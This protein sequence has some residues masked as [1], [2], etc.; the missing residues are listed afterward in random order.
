MSAQPTVL[1]VSAV[2]LIRRG[3]D[4]L[5]VESRYPG[6]QEPFWALPGG[7]LEDNEDVTDALIREVREETGLA[8]VGPPSVAALIWLRTDD[9]S[10]DWVTFI[11]EPSGWEGAIHADDPDGVTLQ[12]AF[13]PMDD[14]EGLLLGLRW[15]LSEPI[16]QRLRGAPLG[17]MWTYRWNGQGPWDGGGPAEL[18]AGPR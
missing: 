13:V 6:E 9:G 16:V 5:L 1:R 12:A 15:G 2:A 18:M 17:S 10:S 11:C 4:V 3:D 14:A 7:M 8:L